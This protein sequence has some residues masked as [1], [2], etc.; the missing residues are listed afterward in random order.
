MTEEKTLFFNKYH[1][2]YDRWYDEH[3][4][5]YQD[6]LDFISGLLPSGRG[7]E[8]G[9][10]TGRFA[11][12]LGISHGVDISEKMVMLAKLR[13]VDAV[14]ANAVDLPYENKE[15]DFSLLMVT[16]CFLDDPL[17]AL[18]EAERVSKET[19]SVILDRECEY[20]S[21]IA[22]KQEGFYRY[23]KFYSAGELVD[24]YIRAGFREVTVTEEDLVT[25]DGRPYR[26]VAVSGK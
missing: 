14:V 2:E 11:S 4:K 18:K 15:F 10:G 17:G 5:E 6:Q 26:L 13:G 23:A 21:D 24:L 7:L 8:I 20:I 3:S 1:E 22:E 19:I 16:L 12:K 25:S 9:V